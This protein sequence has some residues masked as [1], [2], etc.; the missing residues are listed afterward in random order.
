MLP[1]SCSV[2]AYELSYQLI[3]YE[4]FLFDKV[5][6]SLFVAMFKFAPCGEGQAYFFAEDEK[7]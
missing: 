6:L 2:R 7:S 5:F 3:S 1:R 4:L